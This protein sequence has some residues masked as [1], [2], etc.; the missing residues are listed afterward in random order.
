[1]KKQIHLRAEDLNNSDKLE[2]TYNLGQ[3]HKR[4]LLRQS[5]IMKKFG[6]TA[7]QSLIIAYLSTHKKD[8]V[9]QKTLEEHLHLT[10]PT[11]TV[12]VKSM[13]DNGLIRKER[14]P[15]DARKYRLY[16]TEKAKQVEKASLQ[17]AKTLDQSFY[18]GVLE[19][20]L[21]V[22]KGVLGQI[23]KNLDMV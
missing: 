11:I 1:M 21:K 3:V 17:A 18:E 9:T 19:S 14:V 12:M 10:N 15:E 4:M 8:V 20:D 6:L 5:G 23:A 2:L 16:M 7:R 13:I 22:F